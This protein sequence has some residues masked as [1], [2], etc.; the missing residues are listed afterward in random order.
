MWNSNT[1][2][3]YY[4][5]GLLRSVSK[6]ELDGKGYRTTEYDQYGYPVKYEYVDINSDG[7]SDWRRTDYTWTYDP[8]TKCPT[9]VVVTETRSYDATPYTYKWVF[10]NPMKVKKVRNCD[11]FGNQVWLGV[12]A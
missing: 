8:K 3:T 7:S 9:E 10:S 5:N 4:K 2:Y 11:A 12:D 1:S 6:P